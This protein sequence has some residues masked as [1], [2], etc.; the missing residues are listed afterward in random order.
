MYIEKFNSLNVELQKELNIKISK[1]LGMNI[2][3]FKL[4]KDN[5][6]AE[7]T[8]KV[9]YKTL[10]VSPTYLIGSEI[11]SYVESQSIKVLDPLTNKLVDINMNSKELV[12][13]DKS[14]ELQ[15][16]YQLIDKRFKNEIYYISMKGINTLK[17]TNIDN[18]YLFLDI[19]NP[20]LRNDYMKCIFIM[21]NN[22]N[23]IK[24]CIQFNNTNINTME[25]KLYIENK[26]NDSNIEVQNNEIRLY[27]DSKITKFIEEFLYNEVFEQLEN[28]QVEIGK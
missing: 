5:E 19:N 3:S 25:L 17:F 2:C 8:N 22:N 28:Q 6:F 23:V 21:L 9:T 12:F 24:N 4:N 16:I 10:L 11:N 20:L 27:N 18:S 13:F 7:K 1:L 26:N 15:L 14:K